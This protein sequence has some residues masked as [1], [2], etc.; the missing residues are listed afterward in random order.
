MTALFIQASSVMAQPSASESPVT[1]SFQ[2]L[3][4]LHPGGSFKVIMTL[5][6]QQGWHIYAP[7]G[8]NESQG[9]IETKVKFRLPEGMT[10][11][12]DPRL[13]KAHRQGSFEIYEGN[14]IQWQWLVQSR[15]AVRSGE[16]IIHGEIRYQTCNHDVCFPPHTEPFSFKVKVQ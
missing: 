8:D 13:P 14:N 12:G 2:A 6:I 4:S 3:T 16:Y 9:M 11:K 5:N 7:T 1:W 10:L 15:A